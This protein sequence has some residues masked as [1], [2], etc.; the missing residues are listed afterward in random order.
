MNWRNLQS[1]LCPKCGAPLDKGEGLLSFD[2]VCKS[3]CGFSCSNTRFDELVSSMY[4][5]KPRRCGTFESNLSE[6]NNL[7]RKEV[8]DDFEDSPFADRQPIIENNE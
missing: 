4:S 6:I 8:S 5:P 1:F 2:Y 7:G 3:L